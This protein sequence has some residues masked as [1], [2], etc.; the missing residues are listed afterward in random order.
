MYGMEKIILS[1]GLLF[2]L[3]AAS[4]LF[5]FFAT[6]SKDDRPRLSHFWA[7]LW[8]IFSTISFPVTLFSKWYSK[9]DEEV[10]R[11][12]VIDSKRK[13]YDL[14]VQREKKLEDEI[15]SLKE[16]IRLLRLSK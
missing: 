2:L 10:Y 3:F 9:M 16:E 8:L 7:I 11:N 4:V 6:I 1:L 13:S 12:E 5:R 14:F 15:E